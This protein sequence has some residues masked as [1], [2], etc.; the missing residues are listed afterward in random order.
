MRS[1]LVSVLALIMAASAVPLEDR[2][3]PCGIEGP[4]PTLGEM[5]CCGSGFITCD[6]SGW[7]YRPCGQGTTCH[8]L[9]PPGPLICGWPVGKP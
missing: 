5:K 6:Y 4:C 8:E 1:I 3:N 7:V 2:A 9:P